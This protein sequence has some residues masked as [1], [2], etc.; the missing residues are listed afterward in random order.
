MA[1]NA[2]IETK[3]TAAAAATYVG[4]T[5][6]LAALTAV[7]DHHELVGWMPGALA[8]FVLAVVPT[9]ISFVAAWCAKHSPRLP[10]T[11]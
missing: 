10:S 11:Q 3:V 6:V 9:A 5:G 2:P 8:P 7:A 1:N 4:S